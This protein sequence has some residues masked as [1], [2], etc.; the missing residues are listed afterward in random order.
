MK[1]DV[2]LAVVTVVVVE[3]VVVVVD[4]VVDVVVVAPKR[5]INILISLRTI[6]FCS[7]ISIMVHIKTNLMYNFY[8]LTCLL[9]VY[10]SV[11]LSAA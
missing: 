9:F 7:S 3:E 8:T 1:P 6:N 11:S 2:G 4:V 5:I 10:L